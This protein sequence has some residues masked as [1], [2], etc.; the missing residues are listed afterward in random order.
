MSSHLAPQQQDLWQQY[1]P[2]FPETQDAAV[3]AFMSSAK[4]VNVPNQQM[5]FSAGDPCKNYLLLLEGCIRVQLI[6]ETGR[7]VML[8]TVSSGDS[9]VLTTSCLLEDKPY[10]AEAYTE[11]DVSA[12]LIPEADFN[13]ALEQSNFFRKYVFNNFSSRLSSVIH[14]MEE[15][16]LNPLEVRLAKYLLSINDSVIRKTHQQLASEMGTAREVISRHL[17]QL[18]NAGWIAVSRGKITVIDRAALEKLIISH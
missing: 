2:T 14:R 1:F 4:L 18:K 3:N 12:F 9:C 15:V 16:V 17:K 7:E 6:A 13:Q 8:Y 5:V 11:G 10:P